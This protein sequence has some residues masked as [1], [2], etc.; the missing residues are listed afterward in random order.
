[1]LLSFAICMSQDYID[2]EEK[3]WG[4]YNNE[5]YELAANEFIKAMQQYDKEYGIDLEYTELCIWVAYSYLDGNNPVDAI[6]YYEKGINL[7]N[8]ITNGK[9]SSYY[10]SACLDLADLYHAMG[11]LDKAEPLYIEAMAI[12]KKGPETDNWKYRECLN[13]L[14]VLYKTKMQYEAAW[15]L[16]EENFKTFHKVPEESTSEYCIALLQLAEMRRIVGQYENALHLYLDT[17]GNIPKVFCNDYQFHSVYLNNLGGLYNEMGQYENAVPIYLEA[18]AFNK[19]T[20]NKKNPHYSKLLINLASLYNN[21]GQYEKAIQLFLEAIDINE[22]DL[23]KNPLDYYSCLNGLALSYFH[24][25]QNEKSLSLYLK[26]LEDIELKLSKYHPAYNRF[27]NDLASLYRSMGQYEKALPLYLKVLEN[28]QNDSPSHDVTLNNIAG[29]YQDMGQYERALLLYL[30]ALDNTEN[31]LGTSH[32]EYGTCLSNLAGLYRIM[33]RY[34]EALSLQLKSLEI[35]ETNSGKD[36]GICLNNLAELYRSMGHYDKA[37]LL[38]LE[39]LK[40][41]ES[42]VGKDHPGYGLT[43]NNMAGLFFMIGQYDEAMKYFIKGISIIRN[44]INVNFAFLS[45]KEKEEYV[46]TIGKTFDG[47][48]S[49]A[50]RYKSTASKITTYV[51][52]NTLTNKGILLKSSTAMRVAVLSSGDTALINKF[53]EWQLL[54]RQ[55]ARLYST[56]KSKRYQNPKELEEKATIIE[57]QLVSGSQEFSDYKNMQNLSWQDVQKGLKPDEAAIEFISFGFHDKKW[58][59]SI[60]YCALLLKHDSKYPEMIQLFEENELEDYIKKSKSKSDAM[61]AVKLYGKKRDVGRLSSYTSISYADS[62]YSLIWEPLDSL[63]KGIETVYYSPAGLLHS[64][65]F[66]AIPYNDSL[67]LSDKYDL[68]YVSTTGRIARPISE[69]ID[70]VSLDVAVYGGLQYDMTVDEI[71]ANSNIYKHTKDN[72]LYADKRSL[73]SADSSRGDSWTYLKGTLLESENI[74]KLLRDQKVST[75]L[76]Q[77]FEGN[78]ESFKSLAGNN[79]PGIIHL[80]T[81]GFFFPDP[82]KEKND[83]RASTP[84]DNMVFKESDNPLIRSGVIM[85]GANLA[86]K[87]LEISEGVDDGILTAYEVS[88][89]DLFNTQLVVLSACE[90]GLGD[91]KGSEGVYGLQRSFKMAGVDYLIM[92][93][94]QV[95]DKET[96]EFMTLFYTQLLNTKNIREAFTETQRA[97]L[98]KYDPYY[99]AAFVLIE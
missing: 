82:E 97:M 65:S 88:G 51:F 19:K 77:G 4:Y 99:W 76:Y 12:F 39:A 9:E 55:I 56:E 68:V 18:L 94:W 38:F 21:M 78:E 75:T 66:A 60:L 45:E 53:D 35:A 72:I 27:I 57:R 85:S 73:N 13:N 41:T 32:P 6:K 54:N 69:K 84:G 87:G 90:T 10:A 98:N 1:M 63:L 81:H 70:F 46:K 83:G 59:D 79:S 80:A 28:D 96:S 92:S 37:L 89:M 16:F 24:L 43:V 22:P 71:L 91:I 29:L 93:L 52:D 30:E 49:F 74:D 23:W 95:P 26:M 48:N 7:F 62:L 67:L 61:L 44:N 58:T 11:D 17:L 40:V 64:I 5:Q 42:T 50:L 14:A 3:A 86:W 2:H 8:E 36:Y 33:G 25:G 20:S 15:Q 47:F 34:E 31:K